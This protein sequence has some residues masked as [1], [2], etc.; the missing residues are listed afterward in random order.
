LAWVE[1][2][3]HFDRSVTVRDSDL[4]FYFLAKA[5]DLFLT[6]PVITLRFIP[7]AV[8]CDIP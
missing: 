4:T 3:H 5:L 6:H 7:A 2:L 8:F 1:T